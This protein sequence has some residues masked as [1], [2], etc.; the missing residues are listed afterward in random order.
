MQ[1]RTINAA[2]LALRVQT[3]REDRNGLEQVEALLRLR[4]F[5]MP[6]VTRARRKAF[7]R[8]ELRRELAALL[9]DGPKPRAALVAHVQSAPDFTPRRAGATVSNTAGQDAESGLGKSAGRAVGAERSAAELRATRRQHPFHVRLTG[10][11]GGIRT[12]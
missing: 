9:R 12:L 5:P 8:G 11:R 1:D 3:I 6:E 10:T 4:R 7:D 2:L